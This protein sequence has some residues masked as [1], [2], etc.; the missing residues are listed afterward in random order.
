MFNIRIV[1]CF[2]CLF[3][4]LQLL[5]G[6]TS[7][8]HVRK[9]I[10]TF[11]QAQMDTL[12]NAIIAM[13]GRP[14]VYDASFSAYDYFANLHWDASKD[15]M[16]NAH[17]SPGF[18]TWHRE[19]LLRFENELRISTNNPDY[20]LPYWDWTSTEAFNKIFNANAFGGNGLPTDGWIVQNGKFGKIAD[21]F[22]VNVYPAS[23]PDTTPSIYIKR[24]FAWL[25][26]VNTLPTASEVQTMMTKPVYDVAPWGYY[27]DTAVSFR[28]YLEGYWNGPNTDPNMAMVGDGM[29]G[30]VHIFVG[31]NMV[32]DAS[33]NDPV[34]FLHHA[35]VDR[36]WAMWQDAHGINNFTD[37]WYIVEQMS[38]MPMDT[39]FFSKSD[40]LYTFDKTHI[41]M[42]SVY[43]NCYRYDT[44]TDL[45]QLYFA[46]S[47]G[48]GFGNNNLT[49]LAYPAPS[50]YVA[51][52]GDCND[53][54]AN[55]H[56]NMAEIAGNG[57]D[58]DCNT[59]IDDACSNGPAS[60]AKAIN[61]TQTSVQIIWTP[62]NDA[63][64]YNVQYRL[65]SGTVW[66]A[67]I[68][69]S[70]NGVAITG[71]LP[72]TSYVFRIRTQCPSGWTAYSTGTNFTT[73]SNTSGTCGKPTLGGVIVVGFSP[74]VYWNAVPTAMK[75][76]VRYRSTDS[77]AWVTKLINPV[78]GV[79]AST[80]TLPSLMAGKTYVY[81]VAALC[82]PGQTSNWS[83]YSSQGTFVIPK[84]DCTPF[85][86]V[87]NSVLVADET[88]KTNN[89]E[90]WPNPVGSQLHVKLAN[91]TKA[92]V[93]VLDLTGRTLLRTEQNSPQCSLDVATLPTGVYVLRILTDE[94]GLSKTFVKG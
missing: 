91:G 4:H 39:V 38:G 47:D 80:T 58:D 3:G 30:R 8:V 32:A 85:P 44:Q 6:Q 27:S 28:N 12:T 24:H 1:V 87:T 16:S 50:G 72:A 20:M 34:F 73:M 57:V 5:S 46:D 11:S 81:Q 59:V 41:D 86:L 60:S 51:I 22:H 68:A 90:V 70:L 82:P 33:P 71:L 36:L 79:L 26:G 62:V 74:R 56:P 13:K 55:I 15:H 2:L 75:Y 25:P 66:S 14:S 53:E 63:I 76:R 18:M 29:H 83:A 9:A 35:N 48:D 23:I 88:P 93:L 40:T 54:N 7:C 52:C 10:T 69:T 31:N 17:H 92:T 78:G 94:G 84:T 49:V 64:K 43:N 37:E 19:F 21:D 61:Q 77:T 42:F 45:S 65:A 67:A 89:I